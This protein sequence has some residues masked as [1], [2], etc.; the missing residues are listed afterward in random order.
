MVQINESEIKNL[1]TQTGGNLPAVPQSGNLDWLKQINDVVGNIRSLL[2]DISPY[3]GKKQNVMQNDN[4]IHRPVDIPVNGAPP[5]IDTSKFV[6]MPQ[7]LQFVDSFLTNLE[8]QGFADKTITESLATLNLKIRDL[9]TLYR[10][11]LEKQK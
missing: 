10:M 2:N 4:T 11:W 7:I 5:V 9:H 6:T 3:L 1:V 8:N